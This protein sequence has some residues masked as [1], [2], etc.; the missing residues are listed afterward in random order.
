VAVKV[1]CDDGLSYKEMAEIIRAYWPKDMGAYRPTE[2]EVNILTQ[3]GRPYLVEYIGCNAREG[4]RIARL[5]SHDG[6]VHTLRNPKAGPAAPRSA[7]LAFAALV[8]P[9]YVRADWLEE[10]RTY[11]ADLPSRRARLLWLC[12]ELAGMPRYSYTVRTSSTTQELARS[13]APADA[14]QPAPSPPPTPDKRPAAL[15]D[16]ATRRGAVLYAVIGGLI[17]YVLT[18]V[19]PHIHISIR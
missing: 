13:A 10:H 5:R 6:S 2:W 4:Q 15:P 16:P 17:V 1:Y 12:L 19:L 14:H 18:L 8:L 11:L 7:V 9:E 3:D